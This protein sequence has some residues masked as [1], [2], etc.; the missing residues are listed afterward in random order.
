MDKYLD[1]RKDKNKNS[2]HM[3]QNFQFKFSVLSRLTFS[4]SEGPDNV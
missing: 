3:L 4:K 2:W 1:E